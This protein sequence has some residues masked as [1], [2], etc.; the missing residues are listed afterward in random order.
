MIPNLGFV[1]SFIVSVLLAALFVLLIYFAV[2]VL[3]DVCEAA[4]R[5]VRYIIREARRKR[6]AKKWRK[7]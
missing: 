4:H 5:M 3:I 7:E 6:D 2:G 1:G